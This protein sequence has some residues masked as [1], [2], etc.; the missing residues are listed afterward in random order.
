MG[1]LCAGWERG[2]RASGV[3][4]AMVSVNP[5]LDCRFWS[6]GSGLSCG[7]LIGWERS[8]LLRFG[9]TG[10]APVATWVGGAAVFALVAIFD[11]PDEL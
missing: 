9:G 7:G 1:L 2:T 10:E 11:T 5:I 8:A 4:D 3:G 6:Y